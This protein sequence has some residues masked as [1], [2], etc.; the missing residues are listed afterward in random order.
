MFWCFSAGKG[1]DWVA[2]ITNYILVSAP[3][4]PGRN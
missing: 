1:I 4:S 3:V 2:V